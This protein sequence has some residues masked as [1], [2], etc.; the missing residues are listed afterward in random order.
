MA[1]KYSSLLKS[2]NPPIKHF[3][4]PFTACLS[5]E[6]DPPCHFRG[7]QFQRYA[8]SDTVVYKVS[9]YHKERKFLHVKLE[10]KQDCL[11]KATASATFLNADQHH[12]RMSVV[13]RPASV[14]KTFRL[15]NYEVRQLSFEPG[16]RQAYID[17]L[18]KQDAQE[19]NF[20]DLSRF[21]LTLNDKSVRERAINDRIHAVKNSK[22][23]KIK[24]EQQ[25][26]DVKHKLKLKM[27]K[28]IKSDKNYVKDN[29]EEA[30]SWTE[31]KKKRLQ[32]QS[33]E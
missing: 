29:L 25:F 31:D 11:L 19:L 9:R 5:T 20:C 23:M 24:F 7:D 18:H 6:N 15:G 10:V 16:K 28:R 17:M 4:I 22:I 32:V 13:S 2:E 12:L 26:R 1:I 27:Q 3:E 14:Q 30:L 33:I 21:G 8:D